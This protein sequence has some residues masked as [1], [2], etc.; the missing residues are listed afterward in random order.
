MSWKE[1]SEKNKTKQN[2]QK[3]FQVWAVAVSNTIKFDYLTYS[4]IVKI[5]RLHT[6]V[7]FFVLFAFLLFFPSFWVLDPSADGNIYWL[8]LITYWLNT[9]WKTMLEK[10]SHRQFRIIRK[11]D[12]INGREF[13]RLWLKW[14]K[15]RLNI[16]RI[17]RGKC[18]KF[19][20]SFRICVQLL[21]PSK[22][23]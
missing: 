21:L 6:V 12:V 13:I 9:R 16:L 20:F 15:R 1:H 11:I 8:M 7:V 3:L 5:L 14:R 19:V 4:D 17:C 18:G 23:K 2:T 10:V 22:G